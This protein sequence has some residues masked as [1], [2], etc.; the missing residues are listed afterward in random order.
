MNGL[1]EQC[2][3]VRPLIEMPGMLEIVGAISEPLLRQ[4]N[5]V[6]LPVYFRPRLV[7]LD[8][9]HSFARS[10]HRIPISHRP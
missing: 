10:S 7:T 8:I 2:L 5:F 6:C 9:S 1:T 3:G 4:T